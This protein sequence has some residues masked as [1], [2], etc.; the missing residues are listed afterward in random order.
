MRV[1]VSACIVSLFL[2]GSAGCERQPEGVSATP[3]PEVEQAAPEA[4][5]PPTQVAPVQA[6]PPL[7][8]WTVVGHRMPGVSAMDEAQAAALHGQALTLDEDQARFGAARC[9]PVAYAIREVLAAAYL[10]EGYRITPEALGL[11]SVGDVQLTLV[12]LSCPD[13][14]WTS[15]GGTLLWVSSDRMLSPWDGVFFELRAQ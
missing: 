2:A 1:S 13:E 5:P 12:D 14:A 15:L 8:E 3:E 4:P 7:G 9:R 10:W 6:P 11:D